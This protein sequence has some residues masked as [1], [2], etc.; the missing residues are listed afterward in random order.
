MGERLYAVKMSPDDVKDWI[1]GLSGLRVIHQKM[2]FENYNPI[3]EIQKRIVS[4]IQELFKAEK[5]Q[6]LNILITGPVGTGKTHLAVSIL[7][8]IFRNGSHSGVRFRYV[9]GTELLHQIRSTYSQNSGKSTEETIERF[10]KIPY[11]LIDDFGAEKISDWA[12]EIFYLIIDNRYGDERPTVITSNLNAK[13][14]AKKID[15]RLMSRI[16]HSCMVL[17]MDGD[18]YRLKKVK[19]T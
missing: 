6:K 13:E 4:K 3:T 9:T 11:L 5:E 17:T 18:D 2:E 10:S 1:K 14:L 12:R 8:K 15:D 7:K 19:Q 16:L